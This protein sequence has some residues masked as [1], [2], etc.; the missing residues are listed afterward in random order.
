MTAKEI[1]I[2]GAGLAGIS[3]AWALRQRG[4]SVTVLDAHDQA[5]CGTS[6]AN[7]GALT[8]S[9]P[10]PWNAP[11]VHWQLLKSLPDPQSAMKLRLKPL[12]GLVPWGLRF[13]A[14]STRKRYEASC[15]ANFAL[16]RHS[17]ACTRAA[18]ESEALDY[19]CLVRGTL[20][21]CSDRAPMEERLRMGELLKSEGLRLDILDRDQTVAK[22]P[23]LAAVADRIAGSIFYPD[24]ESGDARA[25]TRGL[26][27][28][29]ERA[30]VRFEWS[31]PV[32]ELVDRGGRIAGVRTEREEIEVEAIVL[33][34][35]HM[36]WRLLQPHGLH[37][38]VRPVKGYSLTLDMSSLDRRPGL[39]VVD[40]S[41]HIIATPMGD[42][43]RIAGT[44]EFAGLDPTLREERVDNLRQLLKDLYPDLV[45]P[46]LA[47]EQQA[48]TGFRPMS[49]DGRAFIGETRAKG[50]W[51]ITGHGHLGWT[52]AMGSGDLLAALMSDET[53]PV[54]A[55]PFAATRF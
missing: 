46:L 30:G 49:A 44:A 43:L 39:P 31:S 35:G 21:V 23:L 15:H 37:L 40:E 6:F 24:D 2:V 9:E 3:A 38:P 53:P 51:L 54:P 28:A 25:F 7:A 17:L 18:R 20:K 29:A 33:A 10:E 8:P 27:A 48:W 12:P 41:R 55:E 19:D 4:H 34:T 14:N 32:T 47:G 45:D 1:L 16:A 5:A 50:L 13:L 52:Q 11:G 36:T 22:E 26:A 42:R